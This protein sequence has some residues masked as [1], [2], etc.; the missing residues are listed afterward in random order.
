MLKSR[1]PPYMRYIK[2]FI[3]AGFALYLSACDRHKET[4]KFP[5][6]QDYDECILDHMANVSSD[7][8]A[9]VIQRSCTAQSR[10]VVNRDAVLSSDAIAR[11]EG[12]GQ[13]I[14]NNFSGRIYNGNSDWLVTQLT[15]MLTPDKEVGDGDVDVP[16]RYIANVSVNP[17]TIKE[18]S[19]AVL[20]RHPNYLWSITDARGVK[21]L[22]AGS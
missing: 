12:S 18:F 20:N 7:V 19:I 22:Q 8:A 1:L 11:L 5:L 6:A 3:L 17:L 21:V 15:I 16:L 4:S 9:R 2:F 13:T 14:G 10:V